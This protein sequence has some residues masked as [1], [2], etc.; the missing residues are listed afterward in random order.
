MAGPPSIDNDLQQRERRYQS[1]AQSQVLQQNVIAPPPEDLAVV[2][3]QVS[4]PLWIEGELI[5]ARRVDVAGQTVIQ[6][7]W[8]NWPRLRDLLSQEAAAVLD[9]FSLRAVTPSAGTPDSNPARL[10]AGLPIELIVP[11]AVAPVRQWSPTL[12]ALVVAWM[13]LT[14]VAVAIGSLLFGVVSLSERR[15]AFVSA[16]THELRTPL[17]TFRMYAEM[18]AAGMVPD[19]KQVDYLATL[20]CEADRLAHLVENVL[21]YARLERGG[22][23]SQKAPTTVQELLTRARERLTARAAESG[24]HLDIEI[25]RNAEQTLLHTDTAAVEQILLNLVDNACKYAGAAADKRILLHGSRSGR[26]VLIDIVDHGKGIPSDVRR[27]LFR[28]FSKSAENAA[29]SAPGVGLGL[30]LCRRLSRQLGGDLVCLRS[31]TTG[32]HFRLQLPIA[33]S[34]VEQSK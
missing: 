15:A 12:V 10:L 6:G 22:P 33:R 3:E 13:C 5:L 32:T 30:A 27:R 24:M 16:V 19:E 9:D 25:D 34:V 1:F 14:L 7:C 11:E 8:L 2:S 26:Q 4:K 21:A 18:L 29:G 31:D 17:T 20:Q 28:P 23:R